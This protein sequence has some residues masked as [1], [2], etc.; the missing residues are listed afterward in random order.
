[1]CESRQRYNNSKREAISEKYTNSF[2]AFVIKNSNLGRNKI[3]ILFSNS[4]DDMMNL[5]LL[6]TFS[7]K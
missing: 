7:E 3:V 4:S 2:R 1:V 6:P 5:K